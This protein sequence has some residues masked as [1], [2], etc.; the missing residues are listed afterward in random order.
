MLQPHNQVLFFHFLLAMTRP[1][2]CL[3]L[4]LPLLAACEKQLT[5][6]LLDFIA[7]SNALTSD[8]EVTAPD[9]FEVRA[10]AEAREQD[11]LLTR[12]TVTATENKYFVSPDVAERDDITRT[13]LDTVFTTPRQSFLFVNRFGASASRGRQTWRYTVYDSEGNTASRAYTITARP[14]DSTAALHGYTVR[15]Q[16]PRQRTSRAALAAARS[17]VLPPHATDQPDYQELVDLLYVPTPTGPS[18][19]AP[20]SPQAL[21]A[22]AFRAGRWTNRRRTRLALTTLNTTSFDAINT[23]Q[24]VTNAVAAVPLVTGAAQPISKGQ[25]LAFRTVDSLDALLLV[26]DVGTIAPVDL[27]VSVKLRRY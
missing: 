8:R 1:T 5:S 26:R 17:F 19:A 20:S 18:L 10:F 21:T 27:V 13:Y 7:T 3:L 12:F 2:A 24:G 6:P 15:L 25:V 16:A 9:T 22:R 4:A 23:A 14:S 11:P